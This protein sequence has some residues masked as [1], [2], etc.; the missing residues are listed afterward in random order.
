MRSRRRWNRVD[1]LKKAQAELQGRQTK[2]E[3]E[4]NGLIAAV[5]FDVTP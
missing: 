4:L 3:R 5:T 2:A 1:A